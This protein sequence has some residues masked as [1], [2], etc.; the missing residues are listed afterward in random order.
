MTASLAKP[1]S[2]RCA[3][4]SP[5]G[6]GSLL[7][8]ASLA[9]LALLCA[10]LAAPSAARADVIPSPAAE[11]VA[12]TLY[13]D[14]QG[15]VQKLSPWE[16]QQAFE[17]GLVLVSETRTVELPAGR[18]TLRFDGVAEGLIAQSAAI[19]GLPSGAVERNY[20]YALLSPGTLVE[21]SLGK[22]V[23]VV[24]TNR[25]TGRQSSV[26]ATLVQGPSGL[27]VQTADGVEAL[28]CSG[29]AERLVFDRAPDGLSSKPALSAMID[30]PLAGRYELTLTYL[31]IGVNWQ[32]DYVATLNP[33]GQTLDLLGW[34]TVM[35][36]SGTSF[37]DAPT[38]LVAGKLSRVPVR[39]DRARVVPVRRD[40]WPMDTTTQGQ[41]AMM[42][43]VGAM[44]A[45]MA[46]PPPPPPPP[47]PA[48]M[49]DR[50][51]VT[52][53]KRTMA[54]QS[55]LGDYKLYTLPEPVTVAARQTKQMA[56]LDEKGV[57]YQ[58][59]YV[60]PV[61]PWNDYDQ[62]AAIDA[63][64]VVLRLENK[65]TEGLGKPLPSGALSVMET[66]GG[67]PAFAGEQAVRDVAVGEPADLMIGQG[68][69]VR[70][71]PRLVQDKRAGKTMVR[72]TY[73][74][75]LANNKSI[76]ITVEIRHD[77]SIKFFKV[78]SEPA[79]H[80]IRQG[81]VAWRVTLQ[82]GETRVFRYAVRHAG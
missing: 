62:E 74:V 25:E 81:Q 71:R 26:E 22:P 28:G 57:R 24:R 72:R 33:D 13:R 17:K 35:N 66:V 68:M 37:A 79:R 42:M 51:V 6:G 45:M 2:G 76:P 27:M 16:R 1:P 39:I 56:F 29:G 36:S 49:M 82:P 52:G 65:K 18:H 43:D 23:K 9:A 11:A 64:Q 40:C 19:E 12:V 55:D 61:S 75:D 69:D 54:E 44:P 30:V 34:L 5:A 63:P 4:A 7:L 8:R 32:A 21:R 70:A 80:D 20:D 58:R 15:P 3:T 73:E 50:L 46:P 59:L 14:G 41:T 38:Q 48:P 78:I 77:P 60:V 10:P 47:P 53:A 31:A 67:L